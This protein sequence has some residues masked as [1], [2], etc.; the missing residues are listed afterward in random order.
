MIGKLNDSINWW[1]AFLVVCGV[2]LFCMS[3]AFFVMLNLSVLLIKSGSNWH[4]YSA[5]GV[6]TD[7][8]HIIS[9]LQWC[10]KVCTCRLCR[11][12]NMRYVILQMSNG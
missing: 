10:L 8:W 6:V 12:V 5:H 4:G 11:L 7:Y 1:L 3:V 9:Y 2:V